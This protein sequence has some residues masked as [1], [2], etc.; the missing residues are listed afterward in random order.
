MKEQ[1]DVVQPSSGRAESWIIV[2][3][4][5]VIMLGSGLAIAG[6]QR[7]EATARLYDWQ[8]SAFYDLNPTDQAIYSGLS[9]ASE[10]LWVAHADLLMGTP[11]ERA[12]P[13][14]KAEDLTTE[15]WLLPPFQK[16]AAWTQH[17]EVHWTLA[18]SFSFAG[19]AVYFGSGGKVPG[20]SAYLL[21]LSHVHKGAS[22]V[23]GATV[24]IHADPN[25]K[26]PTNVTRDSLIANGWK[27][28]VPYTGA[29]EVERLRGK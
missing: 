20:Q 15:L 27:E 17:G 24:W 11:E 6:R 29:Q 4:I 9:A 8:I 25:V 1:I 10:V 12:N 28:V 7:E 19:S 21:N 14:P 23:N 3:V 13:W 22:Y 26:A 2:A 16:D 5:G 18:A